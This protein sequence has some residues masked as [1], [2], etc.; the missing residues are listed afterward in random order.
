MG[1]IIWNLL[2]EVFVANGIFDFNVQDITGKPVQL[3]QFKGKV[4]LIVN[5]ASK[6]GLTPQYEGLEGLYEKYKAQGLEVLGFPANEF[7]AQEPG[8]NEEINSFCQMKF[9]I[10]FPMFSK[11]VVK[12]E[13]QHPLYK[14]LTEAQPTAIK[15]P[16]SG[17]EK[18]LA[19][20]GQVRLNPSD[21]LWNFEKFLISRDGKVIAR[22]APD[23][24]PS[25]TLLVKALEQALG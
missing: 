9:G 3:N 10:K 5:T 6:C 19:D 16:E 2:L 8:S 25:D 14:H 21:V 22:F 13:G 1:S 7:L 4:L 11:I 12:G 18:K 20:F 23:M 15:N 17:F 24:A